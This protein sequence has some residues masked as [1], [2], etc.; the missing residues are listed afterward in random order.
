MW[1]IRMVAFDL[2]IEKAMSFLLQNPFFKMIM[3]E[4]IM[5]LCGNTALTKTCLLPRNTIIR[6]TQAICL[7]KKSV[8][9]SFVDCSFIKTLYT[10]VLNRLLLTSLVSVFSYFSRLNNLTILHIRNRD[11]RQSF[12]DQLNDVKGENLCV[13]TF[14][15]LKIHCNCKWRVVAS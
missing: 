4:Y 7:T 14:K 2:I 11:R 15:S 3:R 10:V 6:R 9:K 5:H 8:L 13:Q 1:G 12:I